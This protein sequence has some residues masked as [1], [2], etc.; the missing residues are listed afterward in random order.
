MDHRVHYRCSR[1]H[2]VEK[3]GSEK[4]HLRSDPFYWRSVLILGVD[5]R[6]ECGHL[7]KRQIDAR[8]NPQIGPG[9]KNK[10]VV[11]PGLE[12][13]PTCLRVTQVG[14]EETLLDLRPRLDPEKSMLLLVGQRPQA[15]GFE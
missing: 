6:L 2:Y 14:I 12:P 8:R 4:K 15:L 1:A 5:E 3:L 7:A 11:G 9:R 10:R 13:F